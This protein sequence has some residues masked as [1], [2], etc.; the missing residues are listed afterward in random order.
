MNYNKLIGKMH[1]ELD[2][3]LEDVVNKFRLANPDLKA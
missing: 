2:K 1:E 3:E